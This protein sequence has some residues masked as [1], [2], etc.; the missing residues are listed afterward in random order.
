MKIGI[1]YWYS[2]VSKFKGNFNKISYP[3]F[4]ITLNNINNKLT[5]TNTQPHVKDFMFYMK[6]LH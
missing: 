3:Y 1:Y 5:F 6:I 2:F 4:D